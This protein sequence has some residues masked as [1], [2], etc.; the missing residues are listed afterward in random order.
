MNRRL[1]GIALAAACL[2]GCNSLKEEPGAV[3]VKQPATML[4]A[5]TEQ[6]KKAGI[7]DGWYYGQESR[8][9]KTEYLLTTPQTKAQFALAYHDMLA[10]H[11]QDMLKRWSSYVPYSIR[12]DFAEQWWS[13]NCPA[14]DRQSQKMKI[15]WIHE[16]LLDASELWW[17]ANEKLSAAAIDSP[18]VLAH[19]A[20][21]K[22]VFAYAE[23]ERSSS[24]F[25]DQFALMNA[26]HQSADLSHQQNQNAGG[27]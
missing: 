5:V 1:L 11:N 19:D 6:A 26:R 17:R 12:S 20:E 2:G 21:Q 3:V 16:S 10:A 27:N 24:T 9:L 14:F 4:D 22:L 7:E 15:L 23:N 8:T 25:S 13:K 18:A